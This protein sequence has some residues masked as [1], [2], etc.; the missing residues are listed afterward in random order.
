MRPDSVQEKF[1]G[2]FVNDSASQNLFKQC[3]EYI[4]MHIAKLSKGTL[5]DFYAQHDYTD[6]MSKN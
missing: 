2:F 1:F 3:N 5:M 4:N 6:E